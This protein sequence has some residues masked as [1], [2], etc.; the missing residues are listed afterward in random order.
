[1]TEKQQHKVSIARS[2][3]LKYLMAFSVVVL[4]SVLCRP[5]VDEAFDIGDIWENEDVV[6]N[7]DITIQK[8]IPQNRII[9]S[10]TEAKQP[11]ITAIGGVVGNLPNGVDTTGK[12]KSLVEEVERQFAK[13]IYAEELIAQSKE[14]QLYLLKGQGVEERNIETDYI[15]VTTAKT[16]LNKWVADNMPN[17]QSA[18]SR[19]IDKHLAPNVAETDFIPET[20][21]ASL[22][23]PHMIP[24]ETVLI[25]NGDLITAEKFD[26]LKKSELMREGF[27]FDNFSLISFLGYLLLILLIIG[28]LL[29]YLQ[30][31]HKTV[32]DKMNNLAFVMMF[33]AVISLLVY[34]L[35]GNGI[36]SYVIPF[37]VVPIIIKNFFDERLALFVH[38]V[39]VL[40]ASFLSVHDYEFTFI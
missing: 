9:F 3:W 37:C 25:A 35:E 33:P 39:I 16:E 21:K 6:L 12:F 8:E 34:V 15:S 40:I 23:E 13:G 26:L 7:S 28:A 22:T 32:F 18:V 30:F 4:I 5:K 38:I 29:V 20:M 11:L 10:S 27:S 24:K 19:L 31:T 17:Y 14:G 2:D 36:D 1:M